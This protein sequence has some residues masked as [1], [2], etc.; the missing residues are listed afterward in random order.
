MFTDFSLKQW[1]IACYEWVLT[2][3]GANTATV[4]K[5]TSTEYGMEPETVADA[6]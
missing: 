4:L 6:R 3:I 1:P 2:S 5:L